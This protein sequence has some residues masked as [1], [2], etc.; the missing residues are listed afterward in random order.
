MQTFQPVVVMMTAPDQSTATSIADRLLAQRLCA[1]VNVVPQVHSLFFWQGE[2]QNAEECLCL[3]KT[4]LHLMPQVEKEIRSAHPYEVPE[5]IALPVAW[6]N[7][8]FVAWIE[9]TVC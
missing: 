2:F 4:G 3:I 5:I 7:A 8:D 6:S 9:S 1:C